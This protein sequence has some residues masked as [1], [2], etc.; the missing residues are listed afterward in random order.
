MKQTQICFVSEY[1]PGSLF[2]S[3]LSG[4]GTNQCRRLHHQWRRRD[5]RSAEGL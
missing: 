2:V 4:V 3:E 5:R 1:E